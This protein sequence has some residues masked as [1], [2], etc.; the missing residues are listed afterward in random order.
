MSDN[1]F[2][3]STAYKLSIKDITESNFFNEEME[4]KKLSYAITPFGLKISRV[5][6][7]GDVSY[8]KP[9]ENESTGNVKSVYFVVNDGTEDIGVTAFLESQFNTRYYESIKIARDLQ[10]GDL[11]DVIGRIRKREEKFSIIPEIIRKIN[12]P[13]FELLRDLEKIH[14]KV[15]IKN[16]KLNQRKEISKIIEEETSIEDKNLDFE[17]DIE[18]NSEISSDIEKILAIIEEQDEKDGVTI[19]KISTFT[20]INMDRLKR[21]I[22][23]L[24]EDGTIYEPK[25]GRY[26]KL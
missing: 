10:I 23:E 16:N 12:D 11:V 24:F 22:R 19:E 1:R 21:I 5:R 14:L 17:E 25:S 2:K 20:N 7:L 8:V 26:K 4:D 6:I 9:R 13:N 15:L 18:I 3:R